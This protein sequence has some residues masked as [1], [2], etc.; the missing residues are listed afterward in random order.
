MFTLHRVRA[1]LVAMSGHGDRQAAGAAPAAARSARLSLRAPGRARSQKRVAAPKRGGDGAEPAE[2]GE[3]IVG[4]GDRGRGALGVQ[5]LPRLRR[6][7]PGHDRVRRQDRRHAPSPGAGG[8]ALPERADPRLQG[9]G[10]AVEPVGHRRREALRLGRRA[11][12]SR[13]SPTS[14]TPSTSTTSAAPGAFDDRNKKTTQAVRPAAEEGRRRL[15]VPRARR[16][17][18]TATRRAGSATST[19]T[20]RWRRR[21]SRPLNGY[22]R[23]EGHRRTARTASTRSRTSS[24]SSAAT[25]R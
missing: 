21:A 5:R 12:T 24:R 8:G 11:S 3:N 16:S 9:D 6:G 10:D 14:P 17:S 7:V 20:R 4:A 1:L 15:R 22:E 13:R 18:A 2:V 23:E 19:S 25:T